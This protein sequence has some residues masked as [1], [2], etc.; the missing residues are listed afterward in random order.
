MLARAFVAGSALSD[1]CSPLLFC[2]VMICLFQT[3]GS[4][5]VP[6]GSLRTQLA[7]V[8][9]GATA[10]SKAASLFRT[11]PLN[12][13]SPSASSNAAVG[14]MSRME[15][16]SSSSHGGSGGVGLPKPDFS[17][18]TFFAPS[19]A[20]AVHSSGGPS[21]SLCGTRAYV[22][23]RHSSTP[24]QS[25]GSRFNMTKLRYCTSLLLHAA[26]E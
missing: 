12:Y 5:D 11:K 14:G 24:L 19:A 15:S 9:S 16:A 10:R 23:L 22:C 3:I 25:A 2:C 6:S 8:L 26:H 18:F 7:A 17:E 20:A 13:N 4:F 1:S 21:S